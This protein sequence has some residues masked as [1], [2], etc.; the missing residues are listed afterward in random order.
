MGYKVLGEVK[1]FVKEV[2]SEQVDK[3][4]YKILGQAKDF[5][6]EVASTFMTGAKELAGQAKEVA[7]DAV[8]AAPKVI[9]QAKEAS[10]TVG[11]S[12]K[13]M[14]STPV[15]MMLD[16]IFLPT[17]GRKITEK[18]FSE[19]AKDILRKIVIDNK[20]SPGDSL[21]VDYED[22]NKYGAKM[23]ANFFGGI[24]EDTQSFIGRL[25]DLS[26][27]D[28]VKMTLGEALLK[29]DKKGNVSVEDQYDFNS[30]TFFGKG[31]D[32]NGKYK[33]LT[34]D[35]FEKSDITFTEAL[36]DTIQNSPSSYQMM[37]NLAFLFGSRDYEDD[38]RDTGRKVNIKLGKVER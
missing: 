18:N 34:S 37:R 26:P 1:D 31:K 15:T 5:A 16:D 4:S 29:V 13:A 33:N 28:E 9:E 38:T 6:T 25:S 36:R 17:L 35:E 8:E 14:T 22:F 10:Q 27:A 11:K 19:G 2:S 24:N 12:F 21:K 23:S 32:S 20:L 30:W 7:E 3:P